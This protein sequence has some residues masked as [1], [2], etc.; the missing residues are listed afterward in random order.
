LRPRPRFRHGIAAILVLAL[1]ARLIAVAATPDFAPINDSA[2]FDRYAVSLADTGRFPGSQLTPGPTAFRAPLFPLAL[3]GAYELAGG[4]SARSRWRAGRLLEVLLG[5]LTVA[6]ICA[7]ARRVW[8]RGT[9]LVTGT[10]AAIYPPLVL[11]GMSLMSES[12]YIPLV[13]GAV[14][15]ALVA[16]ER[17]NPWP[18]VVLAGVLVGAATLARSTVLLVVLPVAL[19]VWPMP[20]RSWRSARAPGIVVAV[21][22]ATLIPWLVRDARVMHQLVPVTDEGGYALIGTYNSI[23]AHRSD[24]PALYTPPL[25][26]AAR[27]LRGVHIGNEAHFADHLSTAALHYID[28]H[29]AYVLKVSF[30]SAARL[31]DLTGVGFERW[32]EPSW[33]Y[34]RGFSGFSVFAFWITGVLALVGLVSSAA[35][36]APLALWLCP[37]AVLL[38][39]IPVIGAARYRAPA[40]PFLIM[41]AAL[42][43]IALTRRIRPGPAR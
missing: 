2:D 38:P 23:A 42:G 3:A 35:R 7:I 40:D 6:L 18:W 9:A 27:L 5:T 14:L 24:Y 10:I 29:P 1:A 8:G 31:F 26:E 11:V 12:L 4:S 37:V 20:R 21:A 33:G 13:L 16:R 36:R 17:R 41:L 19:L 34:P 39:T 30:F 28:A 43:A 15:A 22:L 25:L 32:I